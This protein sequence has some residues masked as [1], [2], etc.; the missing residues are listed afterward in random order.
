MQDTKLNW[1]QAALLQELSK[2]NKT[3]NEIWTTAE[4]KGKNT[5]PGRRR[6][7]YTELGNERTARETTTQQRTEEGLKSGHGREHGWIKW[8]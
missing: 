4:T 7:L 5:K 1:T 2:L 3:Q 6:K 8:K